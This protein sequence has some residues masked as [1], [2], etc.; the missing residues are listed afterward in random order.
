M[1]A[2]SVL[3]SI[4]AAEAHKTGSRARVFHYGPYTV[5]LL[6][7]GE[8]IIGVAKRNPVDVP[9]HDLGDTIAIRRAMIELGKVCT[10]DTYI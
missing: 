3:Y 9:N 2:N 7:W 6:E 1:S 5:C 4:G 10:Y 8:G